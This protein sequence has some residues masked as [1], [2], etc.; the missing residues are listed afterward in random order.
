MTVWTALALAV[1]VG[2]DSST[3]G[4]DA[5]GQSME[6]LAAKL[7]GKT[8]SPAPVDAAPAPSRDEVAANET[9]DAAGQG[10]AAGPNA[11]PAG[12][13][14]ASD[15]GP[16][17]SRSGTY[18][19]AIS[20]A[21][22]NIRNRLD[23]LPWKDSVRLFQAEMGYKPR[24]TKEFME[25]IERDGVRL[26]DIPPDSTYLYVPEDGQFGELYQVPI[27]QGQGGAPPTGR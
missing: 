18:F 9:T 6:Q 14:Q 27:D 11:V 17:R 3:T 2:C 4:S 15:R 7:Q 19:G 8:D 25:R 23:D 1:F 16:V 26:P 13:K 10:A 5:G 12:A 22:R 24:N 20:S 21:N